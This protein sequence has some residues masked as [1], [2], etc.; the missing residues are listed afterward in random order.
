M[1]DFRE[2]ALRGGKKEKGYQYVLYW[3]PYYDDDQR[4]IRH[5]FTVDFT[6][7]GIKERSRFDT[8]E[9]ADAW[10][11]L[12]IDQYAVQLAKTVLGLN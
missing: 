6:L 12:V 3:E 7:T 4:V 2:L 1:I 9:E 5:A 11:K 8:L 10:I